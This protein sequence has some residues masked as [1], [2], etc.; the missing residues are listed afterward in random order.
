MQGLLWKVASFFLPALRF[1]T[2]CPEALARADPATVRMRPFGKVIRL[3]Q[4]GQIEVRSMTSAMELFE[5]Q[6]E[7]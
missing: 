5:T 4:I 1:A 2:L 6:W 3:V 7:N